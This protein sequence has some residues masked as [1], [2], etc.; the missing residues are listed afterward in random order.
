MKY[1]HHGASLTRFIAF[2]PSKP[3][4]WAKKKGFSTFEGA[5]KIWR[6]E[7]HSPEHRYVHDVDSWSSFPLV[8][9]YTPL[10]A[11]TASTP[12]REEWHLGNI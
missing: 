12:S 4:G 2:S 6:R 7:K 3:E 1:L 10:L 8:I 9:S 11:I 5:D